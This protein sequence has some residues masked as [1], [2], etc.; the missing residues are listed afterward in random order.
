MQT[1]SESAR[2]HHTPS[3]VLV[4][5]RVRLLD[6]TA[7]RGMQRSERNVAVPS[8]ASVGDLL[9]TLG[10]ERGALSAL[11]CNEVDFDLS[12]PGGDVCFNLSLHDGD[13]VALTGALR[14]G[15]A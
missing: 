3:G 11:A 6:A 14:F 15:N 4:F 7:E 8:S 5:V 1:F 13:T 10:I 12:R 9:R 2:H